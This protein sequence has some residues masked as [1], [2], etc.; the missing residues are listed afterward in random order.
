MRRLKDEPSA[1]AEENYIAL[2][3]ALMV[4]DLGCAL[5]AFPIIYLLTTPFAALF[6]MM[7]VLSAP[8]QYTVL[9]RC[10]RFAEYYTLINGQIAALS[11]S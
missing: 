5:A 11:S 6:S 1:L 2:F 10:L 4:L 8:R 7:S 3:Q 9:R